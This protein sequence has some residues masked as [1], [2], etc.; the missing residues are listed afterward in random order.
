MQDPW[1]GNVSAVFISPMAGFGKFKQSRKESG[2]DKF[3]DLIWSSDIPITAIFHETRSYSVYQEMYVTSCMYLNKLKES[4]ETWDNDVAGC[5]RRNAFWKPSLSGEG[6]NDIWTLCL[7]NT[8]W[9]E[10]RGRSWV[11]G[12]LF[13]LSNLRPPRHTVS[14]LSGLDLGSS[15]SKKGSYFGET[16]DTWRV[17]LEMLNVSQMEILSI[18]RRNNLEEKKCICLFGILR[19]LLEK[20]E[21]TVIPAIHMSVF[22]WNFS[23][24]SGCAASSSR[25]IK[26]WMCQSSREK[27]PGTESQRWDSYQS[28]QKSSEFILLSS[29]GNCFTHVHQMVFSLGVI[30]YVQRRL[31][32]IELTSLE[33]QELGCV[34]FWA[35]FCC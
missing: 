31:Q 22:S 35:C 33:H 9:R 24:P 8:L 19:I 28:S 3:L 13:L 20:K 7:R 1:P 14:L 16:V 21:N 26:F 34:E 18:C 17:L 30:S 6:C 29:S 2:E 5:H 12:W 32:N 10:K 23:S 25:G 4:E 11:R 15:C 27:C